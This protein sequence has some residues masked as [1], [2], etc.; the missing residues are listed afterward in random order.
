M[1]RRITRATWKE[2]EETA[3]RKR[4]MGYY[5]AVFGP[6]VG[7]EYF[8]DGEQFVIVWSDEPMILERRAYDSGKTEN[9]L[10]IVGSTLF[11]P[12]LPET[13][14]AERVIQAEIDRLDPKIIVSG[15]AKGI[16][17]L[18]AVFAKYLGI[19]LIEFLP[20]NKRWRPEGYAARNLQIAEACTHLLVIRH[21]LSTTYGSGWTADRAEE[22]GKTVKRITLG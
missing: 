15:G 5:V 2:A 7:H 1:I 4:R 19:G 18:A 21:R 14:E 17:S 13:V 12:G 22:M 3:E 6:P 10:A 20:K 11:S 9:I 16:D 8:S